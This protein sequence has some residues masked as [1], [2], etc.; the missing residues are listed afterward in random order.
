MAV[1]QAVQVQAASTG[2][3]VA[4]TCVLYVVYLAGGHR[5]NTS[6]ACNLTHE[7]AVSVPNTVLLAYWWSPTA[8]LVFCCRISVLQNVP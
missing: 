7:L 4:G 6:F 8:C 5:V 2:P 1:F 3:L